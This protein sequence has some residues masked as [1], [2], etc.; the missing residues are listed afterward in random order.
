MKGFGKELPFL[1]MTINMEG[2]YSYCKCIITRA[3]GCCLFHVPRH[4]ALLQL[5]S[6]NYYNYV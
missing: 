3:G 2:T 1:W 4:D 6:H 5:C